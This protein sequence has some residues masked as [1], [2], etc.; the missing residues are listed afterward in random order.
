MQS[1][2]GQRTSCRAF[3]VD[4]GEKGR[5]GF[6]AA[7]FAERESS[8]PVLVVCRMGTSRFHYAVFFSFHE[9]QTRVN[10]PQLT[11]FEVLNDAE[12]YLHCLSLKQ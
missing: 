4:A 12:E 9:V 7:T 2:R 6:V 3:G 5:G 8:I 10:C 11:L 1:L